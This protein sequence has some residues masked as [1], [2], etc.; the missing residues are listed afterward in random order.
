MVIMKHILFDLIDCPF[1]LLDDKE[2]C[3]LALQ[4]A[5]S[6]SKS[7]LLDLGMHKFEPQGVTGYAL[8]ANSH[9]SIHTWPEKGI[10][11][12]DI[13]TCSDVCEPHKAVE[14]LKKQFKAKKLTSD[15]FDRIL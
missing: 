5:A 12:G 14:Y 7:K 10:A 9:I 15:S 4:I 8:L 2:H 3:Q 6:E 11:K 1:E 13:F